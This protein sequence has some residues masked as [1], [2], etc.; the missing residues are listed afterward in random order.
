M[1]VFLCSLSS[2]CLE[3][4]GDRLAWVTQLPQA[5]RPGNNCICLLPKVADPDEEDTEAGQ[6]QHW[7]YS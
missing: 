6:P 7:G 3:S 2:L 5:T 4:P 1:S